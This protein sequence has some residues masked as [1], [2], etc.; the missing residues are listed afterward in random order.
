M[1]SRRRHANLHF[2]TAQRI[3]SLLSSSTEILYALG[4]GDRVVAVSHQCDFPVVAAQKCRVTRSRIDIGNSSRGIDDQ[5][6]AMLKTQ[7]AMYEIDLPLLV[8]AR[9]DLIV[10]QAQCDVCA[11]R[12]DDVV[13]AVEKCPELSGCEI[14]ALNPTSLDDVLDDIER[15][16]QTAGCRAAAQKLVQS[17]GDRIAIVQTAMKHLQPGQRP[18]VVAIEW[19]DPLMVAGNWMPGMIEMAGGMSRLG[20]AGIHSPYVQWEE[21]QQEDPEL[22]VIMPCGF[23]L[24]RTMHEA[25][26]LTALSGWQDLAAVRNQRVYAVDGNA[27]FN[28]TGPRMV[29]SLEL[30]AHLIHPALQ[31]APGDCQ[32]GRDFAIVDLCS[33]G[34]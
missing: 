26:W 9:P 28:R 22:L 3:A 1:S 16:G 20:T 29:E 25:K 10:T 12:F 23:D 15:I 24:A 18:R 6:Q 17:Y 33:H 14:L 13:A 4:L 5:V 8:E 21:I 11:V 19:I 32:P 2:M 30:L 7:Q 34:E 31:E 27:Y